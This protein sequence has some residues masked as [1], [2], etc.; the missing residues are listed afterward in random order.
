MSQNL[1]PMS[2]LA[3]ADG[4]EDTVH[5]S[6]VGTYILGSEVYSKMLELG[7]LTEVTE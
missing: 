4:G 1:P 7:I 2:F 3:A 6:A 5:L